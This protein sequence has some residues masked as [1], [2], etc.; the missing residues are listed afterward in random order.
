VPEWA[1]LDTD[2]D[3]R[4]AGCSLDHRMTIAI[5]I[6][7]HDGVV[8]AT[9][10]ASSL[11]QQVNG[12]PTVV[13]VYNNANKIFNVRKGL[14]IGTMAWGAGTIGRASVSTLMKELRARLS[15]EDKDHADWHVDPLKYTVDQVAQQ[16]KRFM[17]DESHQ[18]EFATWPQKPVMGMMVVGYSAGARFP[19]TYRID[20]DATGNCAGPTLTFPN[21]QGGINWNG[22]PEAIYR[23]M[24][25][26]S[27]A[28]PGV[29]AKA[30]GVDE[31]KV[32]AAIAGAN[33]ALVA[34][35][36]V[37]PMPIQDAI[38]VAEFLVEVTCKY[39]RYTPGA[40]TVGGPVEIA[41]ITKHEG[42]KWVK[43]KHY[44]HAELNPDYFAKDH[45]KE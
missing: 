44:F 23:L 34:Q 13:Q 36:I 37:D 35:L 14:P 9:D 17:F 26:Y 31:A 20:I 1:E 4:R 28:L 12:A 7:V 21:D 8:L 39:S 6:K 27:P 42:F 10:S 18:K 24:M 25:G 11:V 30:L 3:V 32:S 43:R 5:S 45:T 38:D 2:G 41:A 15:G 29:V 16:V 19:D 22:E 33:P 40:A